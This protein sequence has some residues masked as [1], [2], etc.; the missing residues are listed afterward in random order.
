MRENVLRTRVRNGET[1]YG[2]LTAVYD[3]AIVEAIGHLGFD[4]YMMDSEHGAGGPL[5][6]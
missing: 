6:L 1:A 2:L 3:P 5:E 4:F